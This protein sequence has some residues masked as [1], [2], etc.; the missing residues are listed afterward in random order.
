MRKKFLLSLA[1]LLGALGAW[2]Q[3]Q[4]AALTHNGQVKLYYGASA[5]ADAVE[6]AVHGDVINLSAGTFNGATISKR[7]TVRGAGMLPDEANA[8]EATI[9][10]ELV[11]MTTNAG[12]DDGRFTQFEGIDFSAAGAINAI[13][14]VVMGVVFNKCRFR[15]ADNRNSS[16][17]AN[18]SDCHFYSCHI[19][20]P[21]N[22]SNSPYFNFINSSFSNCYCNLPNYQGLYN[23][24]SENTFENCV[25]N[26]Y[27]SSASYFQTGRKFSNCILYGA[28]PS[29]PATVAMWNCV[30]I[31]PGSDVATIFNN[32]ENNTNKVVDSFGA[33]F[34]RFTGT[35]TYKADFSLTDEAKSLYTGTDGTQIGM[36]GGNTPYSPVVSNPRITKCSVAGK[37][38]TDGKLSV[39]ITVNEGE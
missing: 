28:Q 37:T 9:I 29:I 13:A 31:N 32:I 17:Y 19:T 38:T 15:N 20:G 1:L 2:A 11:K 24:Q 22:A 6:A 23:T 33:I 5:F 4:V 25:I 21:G 10:S 8:T 34:K 7:I 39:D 14:D 30:F 27:S 26:I 12:L 18:F 36:Y 3:T 35:Y 16:T